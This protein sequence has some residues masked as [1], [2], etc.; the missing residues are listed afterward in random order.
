MSSR[1][2]GVLFMV[3]M[4]VFLMIP[5]AEA[6][7]AFDNASSAQVG[8]P[9]NGRNQSTLTFSH[10]ITDVL[11]RALVV[12]VQ[13]EQ[14]QV[15]TTV[16]AVV[17]NIT[18]VTYG[19]VAMEEVPNTGVET[20]A[21]FK[22]FTKLFYMMDAGLP[23]GGA[24]DV[25][26][27]LD[28]NAEDITAGAVS[29]VGVK[30][31][32]PEASAAYSLNGGVPT[33]ITNS[34]TTVSDNAWIVDIIGTGNQATIYA[35]DPATGN[36]QRWNIAAVSSLSAGSTKAAGVAGEI[37]MGWTNDTVNRYCHSLVAFA[38]DPTASVPATSAFGIVLAAG[39][40]ALLSL[41]ALAYAK[42]SKDMQ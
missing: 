20:G 36:V 28:A 34:I 16:D 2:L 33:T 1:G 7:I 39:I 42:R 37:A 31:Q 32:P 29:L 27:T 11:G 8:T 26:V 13:I 4:V 30:Q 14:T 19:G 3:G 17:P 25:V 10:T 12:G 40:L 22:L 15:D 41:L 6:A 23:A 24:H 21:G 35:P 9:D 38:E 18:S 5:N